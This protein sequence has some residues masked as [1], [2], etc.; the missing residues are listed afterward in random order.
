M[1][2]ISLLILRWFFSLGAVADRVRQVRGQSSRVLKQTTRGLESQPG[3]GPALRWG[4][5]LPLLIWLVGLVILVA[6]LPPLMGSYWT[7][8]VAYV[9]LY[10]MLGLGLN[11]VVGF[12]G[13]LDLG[14]VAFYAIGAYCYALA[15]SPHFDLHV[16]FWIMLPVCMI[17]AALSG[18]LLGIPVLRMRGDYL[19]IVTLGFGEII[20]IVMLNLSNFEIAPFTMTWFDIAAVIVLGAALGVVLW[21]RLVPAERQPWWLARFKRYLG[22][23]WLGLAVI[24][25]LI[26][27]LLQGVLAPVLVFDGVRINITNGPQGIFL[28]DPPRIDLSIGDLRLVNFA[29][30]SPI[31]FYYLMLVGCILAAFF[32]DRLNNSRVGRAWVAMREDEDAA[33]MM[34]VDTLRAKLL[35]FGIGA[36]LGGLGGA[37]FAAWQGSI[38]PDDFSLMVSINVLSLIIIGGMGSIPGVLVGAFALIGLPE[39][40]REIQQLRLLFFGDLLMA[41]MIFRP[42][43]FI[44][45]TRRRLEVHEASTPTTVGS[46]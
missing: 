10:I 30:D 15:A 25:G 33:E 4:R 1:I 19:A 31:H 9:G 7:R 2:T 35:A 36:S 13:L 26:S 3:I 41:M 38:F 5:S 42:E 21:G 18:V 39:V 20:R 23:G 24:L 27:L 45:S 32:T 8:V 34:G 46:E 6:L 40:L 28:I 17:V 12:A 11:V 16:A 37:I 22:W 14:Y 43:G 44:P 29:F